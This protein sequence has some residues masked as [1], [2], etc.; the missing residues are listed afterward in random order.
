MYFKIIFLFLLL[1]LFTSCS[2]SSKKIQL[3]K[4]CY[5]EGIT[6]KCRAYF[7]KYEYNQEN[8]KCQEF[9]Y[10]GCGG[11]VPFNTLNECKKSCE[12]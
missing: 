3:P 7:I 6:G 2:D 10:G 1:F 11:N 4:K 9:V 8:G 5:E 12:E